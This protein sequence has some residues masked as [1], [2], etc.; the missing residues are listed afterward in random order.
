MAT[1][2]KFDLGQNQIN[3]TIPSELGFLTN[4]KLLFSLAHNNLSGSI[5]A[6]LGGL[7]MLCKFMYFF[8]FISPYNENNLTQLSLT[9][10]DNMHLEENK[11]ITGTIPLQLGQIKTLSKFRFGSTIG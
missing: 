3:G 6:T 1:G 4:L 8:R 10:K 9:S 2:E 11:N 7:T 5:P